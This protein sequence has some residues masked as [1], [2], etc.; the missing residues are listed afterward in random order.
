MF[1]KILSI[2]ILQALFRLEATS[3]VPQPCPGDYDNIDQFLF[4]SLLFNQGQLMVR[5]LFE[6]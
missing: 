5:N 4:S 1:L 2:G 3:F 6:T